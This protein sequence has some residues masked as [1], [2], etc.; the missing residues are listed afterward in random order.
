MRLPNPPV[1]YY[2]SE[3]GLLQPMSTAQGGL[4]VSRA[5]MPWGD[6][7]DKALLAQTQALIHAR[8]QTTR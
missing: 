2:G 5:P 4:E 7:Q 6:E 3:V 1:I 8:R